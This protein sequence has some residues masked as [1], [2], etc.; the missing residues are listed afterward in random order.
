MAANYSIL[1]RLFPSI[2]EWLKNLPWRIWTRDMR[3]TEKGNSDI[4]THFSW[5]LVATDDE[6]NRHYKGEGGFEPPLVHSWMGG[7][8]TLLTDRWSGWRFI[9]SVFSSENEG[10][11]GNTEINTFASRS[12]YALVCMS[13][14][15]G[16]RSGIVV[17]VIWLI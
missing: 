15:A 17:K 12:T 4:C 1:N 6:G 9:A 11:D 16:R 5:L 2:G 7:G 13:F 10:N 8:L 3:K 14:V